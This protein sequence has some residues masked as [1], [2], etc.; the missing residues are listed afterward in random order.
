MS[1][2]HAILRSWKHALLA[3]ERIKGGEFSLGFMI[4]FSFFLGFAYNALHY[5]VYPGCGPFLLYDGLIS[6]DP[7]KARP[8]LQFWLH[9][10]SGGAGAVALFFFASVL[11][12][13]GINLLGRKIS[14]DK[15]QHLIFSCMFLYLLPL[16]FAF[17]LYWLDLKRYIY[18]QLWAGW[19]GIPLGVAI[20][21]A[22]ATVMAF[23]ILNRAVGFGKRRSAILSLLLLPMLYFLGKGAFMLFTKRI[24]HTAKPLRYALWTLYFSIC[25]L[26]FHLA[27][28]RRK[29]VLPVLRKV[30]LR[31]WG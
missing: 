4:F 10:L 8:N 27:G 16:P 15:V 24:F 12:Y 22:V 3:P 5:F 1:P 25:A 9:H 20:T 26:I 21:G 17:V 14:Y 28:A 6:Y 11:G 13:Y 2:L 30:F 19:V 29:K 31:S 7:S 18:L 23:R